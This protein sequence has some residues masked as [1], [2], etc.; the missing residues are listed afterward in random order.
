MRPRI[1]ISGGQYKRLRKVSSL[2]YC[3]DTGQPPTICL[4][5]EGLPIA[6][7]PR[8]DVDHGDI[9]VENHLATSAQGDIHWDRPEA[10]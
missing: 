8:H 5:V 3:Q 10:F 2:S 7:Q 1:W 9:S 6:L 4:P